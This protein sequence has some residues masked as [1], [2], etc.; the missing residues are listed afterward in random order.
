MSTMNTL[1]RPA[2]PGSRARRA[3]ALAA[4]AAALVGCADGALAQ[5]ASALDS[6]DTAL[7][8]TSTALVLLMTI[9]GVALFYGGM[10]RKKNVLAIVMQVFTI[11]CLVSIL[12]VAIGYSLAFS[13]DGAYVGDLGKLFLDGVE[14]G[15]MSG[16]LPT[17]PETV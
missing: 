4:A 17:I 16:L 12:W 10:V 11:A 3:F 5:E 1:N 14:A 6:G 9:P 7:M 8:L 2:R 15:S 13:G